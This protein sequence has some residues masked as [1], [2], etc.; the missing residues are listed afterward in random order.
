M[1]YKH[2]FF[3]LDRTL[4]DFEENSN[5]TLL[6]LCDKYNFASKGILNYNKFIKKYKFHNEYLWSLYRENKISQKKLRRQRFYNTLLDYGIDDVKLSEKIGL[7]YIE[8]CPKKNKLFPFIFDVLDYLKHKYYLHIIT[9]GFEKTQQIKLKYSGLK[10][11]FLN[12]ITSDKIGF[13]KPNPIIF[14]YALQKARASKSESIYVGDD[15]EVDILGCQNFGIDGVFFNPQ[16]TP[17]NEN[18]TYEISSLKQLMEIF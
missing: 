13:K 18:V 7:D 14:E 3:D 2:I 12:V 5:E 4:W 16:K 15:L 9:N 6:E 10:P 17:H 8:I 1:K 11:F